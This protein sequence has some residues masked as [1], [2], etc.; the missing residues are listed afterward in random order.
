MVVR[1]F[2]VV[3]LHEE[4]DYLGSWSPEGSDR[5]ARIA[6]LRISNLQRAV[7]RSIW[8]GAQGDSLGKRETLKEFEDF[9]QQER[10]T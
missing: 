9:M 2:R 3:V 1:F 4:R 7:A 5:Y 6:G 8:Q 10:W